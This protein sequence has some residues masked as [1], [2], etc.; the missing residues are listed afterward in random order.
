MVCTR[1]LSG[2]VA[3]ILGALTR[4][5]TRG[6]VHPERIRA[7]APAPSP[8][9]TRRRKADIR[10]L[11]RK[12]ECSER[13]AHDSKRSAN[14]VPQRAAHASKRSSKAQRIDTSKLYRRVRPSAPYLRAAS[15]SPCE[16]PPSGR[17]SSHDTRQQSAFPHKKPLPLY[18]GRVR[19]SRVGV[20]ELRELPASRERKKGQPHISS[21]I[22]APVI[23]RPALL[24]APKLLRYSRRPPPRPVAR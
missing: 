12:R 24:S 13:A 1:R 17:R 20:F 16:P 14:S 8:D 3:P 19:F 18:D 7:K 4:A 10:H 15:C 5:I 6:A 9:E 21:P 23:P 2:V 22:F 11:A